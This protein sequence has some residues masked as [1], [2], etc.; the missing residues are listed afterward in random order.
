MIYLIKDVMI[1][2]MQALEKPD[3][4]ITD[5]YRN[6]AV[7][8]ASPGRREKPPVAVARAYQANL[9]GVRSALSF[10]VPTVCLLS[11][12]PMGLAWT[13]S[14]WQVGTVDDA[15][16]YQ[17][18]AG[19]LIQLLS[20]ATLLWPTLFH[21]RFSEHTWLW[22][23]ALA[24]FSGACTIMSIPLFVFLPVAWSMVVAFSGMIAQALIALQIVQTI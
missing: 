15:N 3:G 19:S 14:P 20:L 21:S 22:V 16:F 12:I 23:W 24:V 2:G 5:A 4:N 7:P 17:L 8:N 13:H 6:D 18:L 11:C 1:G 10:F 9:D